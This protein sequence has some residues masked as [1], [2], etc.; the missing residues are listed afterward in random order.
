MKGVKGNQTVGAAIYNIRLYT[1]PGDVC[2]HS[3]MS[4]TWRATRK[5]SE[6]VGG[7]ECHQAHALAARHTVICLS[8]ALVVRCP[9]DLVLSQ[10]QD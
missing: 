10:Q 5:A 2:V 9:A 3:T 8:C 1:Y 7:R 4:D 6:E